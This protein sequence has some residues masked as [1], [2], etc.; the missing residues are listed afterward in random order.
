MKRGAKSNGTV[1]SGASVYD[2]G[3]VRVSDIGVER[4][5]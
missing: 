3:R 1:A 2:F 5:I 4:K